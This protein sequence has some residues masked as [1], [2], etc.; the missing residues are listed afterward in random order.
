MDDRL[1][2]L[3][4]RLSGI[5]HPRLL[6][7]LEGVRKS[8]GRAS[9]RISF[10]AYLGMMV[11]SS[12]VAGVGA[13][14]ASLVLLPLFLDIQL[15]YLIGFSATLGVLGAF[16]A[17][18]ACFLLPKYMSYSRG[19]RID[20]NLTTVANFMSVLATSGMSP[21]NIFRSLARVSGEFGIREEATTIIR[22]IEFLGLDLHTSLKS[23][24]ERSPSKSFATMLD[25]VITTSHMGGDLSSYLRD[26]AEKLKKLK[27]SKLKSFVDNL[28]MIA[29]VYIT[30]MVAAPLMLVVML[31]V[32]AFIG[33]GFTGLDAR[34]LLNLLTFVATPVGVTIMILA[35]DSM[36]PQR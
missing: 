24:S 17:I 35:V 25:G 21:E 6:S 28:G 29:E 32:M 27:V 19:T 30:F 16:V 7:A 14:T 10:Q 26:Q 9:L 2:S 33:G 3:F 8:L 12:L 36:T 31:S 23:A 1:L 22:D 11:F 20:S 34:V 13:F 18:G 4:L 15:L 5:V